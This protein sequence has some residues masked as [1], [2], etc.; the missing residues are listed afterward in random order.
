MVNKDTGKLISRAFSLA[1]INTRLGVHTSSGTSHRLL[2][3]KHCSL[4]ST[5]RVAV[6]RNP[7]FGRGSPNQSTEVLGPFHLQCGPTS[8]LG[9]LH[10]CGGHTDRT[11]VGTEAI[12][13]RLKCQLIWC[14]AIKE[15]ITSTHEVTVNEGRQLIRIC[16][17]GRNSRR[18]SLR[19]GR[20]YL[21]LVSR[22]G[23]GLL[24]SAISRDLVRLISNS[25]WLAR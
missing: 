2:L 4:T 15:C 25:F 1:T 11:V 6:H 17:S 9:H 24:T 14:L 5:G 12:A 7:T 19:V 21:D 10:H 8:S 20:R 22:S 16:L 23:E 18:C 13:T 3:F